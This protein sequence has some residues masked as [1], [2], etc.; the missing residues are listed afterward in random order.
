MGLPAAPISPY[1]IGGLVNEYGAAE[2]LGLKVSTLRRWR[3]AG[4]GPEYVKLGASVRYDPRA[5]AEFVD[6]G[7]RSST[8]D[9]GDA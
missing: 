9:R 6:A 3:W 7:R 8:S 5:L 2:I 4:C 1:R